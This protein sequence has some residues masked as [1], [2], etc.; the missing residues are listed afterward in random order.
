MERALKGNNPGWKSGMERK[1]RPESK[2]VLVQG[3]E[4]G[5]QQALGHLGAK[6]TRYSPLSYSLTKIKVWT[7][8]SEF[9]ERQSHTKAVLGTE[10]SFLVP[11]WLEGHACPI[12]PILITEKPESLPAHSRTHSSLEL[13][14]MLI[15]HWAKRDI[16]NTSPGLKVL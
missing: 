10:D 5:K 6:W 16:N 9:L 8:D 4:P 13:T 15:S 1:S 3:D 2:F 12:L 7:H 11:Q 14:M